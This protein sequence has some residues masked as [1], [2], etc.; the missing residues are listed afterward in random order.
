VVLSAAT[1][2]LIL[3]GGLVTNSGSALAVPDWPTTFG[4]NMFLYPWSQMVGGIFYEHSHRLIG[5]LVG[6]LTVALAVLLWRVERRPWLRRL[7]ALAV[8]FV[9]VQGLVGGLRVVLVKDTLA[10]FHGSIAQA[11]FGLTVALALFT[12]RE[13][14]A[15]ASSSA[16]AASLR[17]L[18]IAT[19]ALLYLQIIFGALLTHWGRLDAHLVT[20]L[21]LFV[22]IPMFGVKVLRQHRD[23][24]NLTGPAMGM[25]LLFVVQLLLGLGAYAVRFTSMALPFGSVIALAFPVAHRLT[26]ALLLGVSL[27]L[28]LRL[29]R[30]EALG[31]ESAMPLKMTRQPL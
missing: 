15:A 13:W 16:P 26:A 21:A 2:V 11:F 10:V 12:S 22:L 17:W 7:G 14:A 31:E 1:L 18:G 30:P 9:C 20:A 27:V 23:D 3:L 29:C 5:S 25:K 24:P 8:L 6:L 19:T 4:Y 28:T